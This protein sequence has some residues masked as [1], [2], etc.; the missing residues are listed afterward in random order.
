MAG[1]MK[2]ELGRATAR[3]PEEQRQAALAVAARSTGE[4]DCRELLQMLGLIPAGKRR[5]A[6]RAEPG[7]SGWR[8]A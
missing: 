8:P 4:A 7:T 1:D 2:T 6:I 3:T 5:A